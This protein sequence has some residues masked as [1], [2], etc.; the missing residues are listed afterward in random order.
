[1]A[2]RRAPDD[3][4]TTELRSR[5]VRATTRDNLEINGAAVL[6]GRG[7]LDAQQYD[8]LATITLWLQ[9]LERAWGGLGGCHGLWLSIVGA[10]T[11]TGSVRPVDSTTSGLADGARR[12]LER[13]LRRLDGSR[14]LVIALAEGQIPDLV[15]HVL[16]GELTG[17]DHVELE[18]LRQGLNHLAGR[19][20]RQARDSIR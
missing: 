15:L 4:G 17:A 10:L 2:G 7:H 3:L 11:P 13:A 16:D 12:Q 18:R 20:T 19:R 9:R 6:F 14:S 8:V 1:L 5:K